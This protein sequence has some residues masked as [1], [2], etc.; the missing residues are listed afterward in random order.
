MAASSEMMTPAI[1]QEN[2]LEFRSVHA[3]LIT[4]IHVFPQIFHGI[5]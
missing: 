5:G 4:K 3:K 2:S 1:D